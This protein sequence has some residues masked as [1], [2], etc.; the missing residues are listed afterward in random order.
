MTRKLFSLGASI[1]L[2]GLTGCF[3]DYDLGGSPGRSGPA[4]PTPRDAGPYEPYDPGDTGLPESDDPGPISDAWL[5]GE[6]QTVGAFDTEAYEIE[7][8]AG[9]AWNPASITLHGAGLDGGGWA[10]ISLSTH[11]EG[12]F[13]GDAFAPGGLLT[14]T[15]GDLEAIGCSGPTHGNWDFDGS[16]EVTVQV[17]AGPTPGS[18]IVHYTATY[19]D[20][21][22]TG[23]SFQVGPL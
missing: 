7:Y 17:E 11:L 19:R 18:R 14:S 12:G 22:T 6:M 4:S 16:G 15:D 3:F 23:G 9:N 1:A 20:G 2:C 13:E 8:V 5:R 10:M 21:Q